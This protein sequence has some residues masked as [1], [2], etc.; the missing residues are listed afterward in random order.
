MSTDVPERAMPCSA[1]HRLRRAR[2]ER[3]GRVGSARARS[4]HACSRQLHISCAMA[5]GGTRT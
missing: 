2:T 1:P 4:R 3:P 5:G